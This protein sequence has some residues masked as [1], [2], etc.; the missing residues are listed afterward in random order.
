MVRRCPAWPRPPFGPREER[1]HR[2]TLGFSEKYGL[3]VKNNLWRTKKEKKYK[4][5]FLTQW[6]KP[7]KI[8]NFANPENERKGRKVGI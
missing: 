5:S 7:K 4:L 6:E 3:R 8:R 1:R 2:V